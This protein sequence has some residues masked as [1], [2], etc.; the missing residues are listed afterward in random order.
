MVKS[1]ESPTQ[2]SRSSIYEQLTVLKNRFFLFLVP[3]ITVA[4]NPETDAKSGLD[5]T[6]LQVMASMLGA[7]LVFGAFEKGKLIKKGNERGSVFLF[8][9]S[10]G[11][12]VVAGGGAA[13]A[14][15]ALVQENSGWSYV[16]AYGPLFAFIISLFQGKG[17]GSF[18]RS[19]SAVAETS[20]DSQRIDKIINTALQYEAG[21]FI[22]SLLALSLINYFFPDSAALGVPD[23]ILAADLFAILITLGCKLA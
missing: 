16:T 21:I 12:Y 15:M 3:L 18:Q 13:I 7:I 1:Q 23:A 5:N 17:F 14:T 22:V 11:L 6:V 2:E 19:R 8:F 9:G 20:E 4:A 10:L